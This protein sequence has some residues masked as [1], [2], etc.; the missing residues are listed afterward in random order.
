MKQTNANL[1]VNDFNSFTTLQ[2]FTLSTEINQPDKEGQPHSNMFLPGRLPWNQTACER[3][4]DRAVQAQKERERT[5]T[6]ENVTGE[7]TDSYEMEREW[8][9]TIQK[10]KDASWSTAFRNCSAQCF[11]RCWGLSCK[12]KVYRQKLIYFYTF[13]P[14]ILRKMWPAH[15]K[16]KFFQKLFFHLLKMLHHFFARYL[17]IWELRRIAQALKLSIREKERDITHAH[18]CLHSLR[19]FTGGIHGP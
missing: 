18:M 1:R 10:S 12:D 9:E 11:L 15:A 17:Q 3:D 5:E 7:H 16:R 8:T 19:N 4:T 14:C 6:W 2:V 13:V